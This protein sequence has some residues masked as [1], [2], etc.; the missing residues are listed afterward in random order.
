VAVRSRLSAFVWR[1]PLGR[2]GVLSALVLGAS[3]CERG[4][5]SRR[6]EDRS[7]TPTIGGEGPRGSMRRDGAA[8]FD[9]AGTDCSDGLARCADGRVEVS[10]AGHVPHPCS[11]PPEKAEKPGSCECPWRTVA[12][13]DSGCVKDGLEVVA[14]AEV[15][16]VQLCASAEPQLRPL[17]PTELTSVSICADEGVSCVDGVVR[18]CSQRGQPVRLVAGCAQGCAGGISVD[19]EDLGTGDGRAVI[20]C[21]RAHAERR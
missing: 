7:L 14:T 13:C 10:V 17:L 5:L 15:A 3:A 4:C 18:V 6:L 11:S 9:L 21:R 20:L 19:L 8:S 1:G 12:S 16:G 2:L